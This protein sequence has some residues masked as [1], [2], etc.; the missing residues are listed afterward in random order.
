[1]AI[2]GNGVH[3]TGMVPDVRPYLERAV[4]TVVPLLSGGGTRLKILE[5]MAAGRAVL[6]TSIGAEGI[7]AVASKEILYADTS[8][9]LAEGCLALIRQ[10]DLRDRIAAGGRQLAV[11]KYDWREA[12][13][14]LLNCY[15]ALSTVSDDA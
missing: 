9:A 6:S 13:R 11:R 10:P 5:A 14:T 2:D 8:E 15:S 4:G 12:Q 7:E 1:M 3:V